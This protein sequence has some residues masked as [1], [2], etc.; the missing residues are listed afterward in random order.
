MSSS[1][2][3]KCC[4]QGIGQS[5]TPFLSWVCQPSSLFCRVGVLLFL[6]GNV[7][8][9]VG[10]SCIMSSISLGCCAFFRICFSSI[11]SCSF[12]HKCGLQDTAYFL[13]HSVPFRRPFHDLCIAFSFSKSMLSRAAI[14]L[15][16]P[17]VASRKILLFFWWLLY[18]LLK[19]VL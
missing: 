19:L 6:P 8:K 7:A 18:F 10:L 13:C 3:H 17:G 4:N 5:M 12:C 1:F 16:C 15:S 14:F 11:M 9:T 2:G